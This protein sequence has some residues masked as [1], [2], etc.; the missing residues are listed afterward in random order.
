MMFGIGGNDVY[1]LKNLE[2]MPCTS[3]CESEVHAHAYIYEGHHLEAL[4]FLLI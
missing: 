2:G 4:F 3:S 1:V